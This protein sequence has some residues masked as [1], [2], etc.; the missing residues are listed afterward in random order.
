MGDVDG[1]NGGG[2]FGE[3]AAGEDEEFWG[4]GGE[5]GSDGG[6]NTK[7]GDAGYEDL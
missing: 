1:G 6:A 7:G 2:D 4:A 3:G 5:G